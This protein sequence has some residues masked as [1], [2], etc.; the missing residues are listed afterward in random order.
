[1]KRLLCDQDFAAVVDVET[2][3]GVEDSLTVEVVVDVVDGTRGINGGD[4]S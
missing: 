4:T 2:L 1:M 3:R